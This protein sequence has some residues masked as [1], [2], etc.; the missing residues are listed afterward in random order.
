MENK[1]IAETILQEWHNLKTVLETRDKELG[2]TKTIIERINSR[3]DE[4]EA[5]LHKT[6]IAKEENKDTVSEHK[7]IF[8]HWIKTGEMI[9]VKNM[10]LRDPTTG[11]FLAPPEFV[12]KIIE[13]IV[14]FSPIREIASVRKT[15]QAMVQIPVDTG[16]P[17]FGW[18]AELGD[19]QS[20]RITFGLETINTHSISGV[21]LITRR[22][23]EDVKFDLENFLIDKATRGFAK[24]E[25][26]AFINGNSV[27]K[28]EGILFNSKI[29][30]IKSGHATSITNPDVLFNMLY[31]LKEAYAKNATW[32]MNRSTLGFL[33]T[34]KD[35]E[36][37]YI[38]SLD[39]I[40]NG[41]PSTLLGLPYVIC[42]DM[43]NIGAGSFPIVLGDF[44][45]GYLIVDREDIAVLRDPYS[46]ATQGVIRFIFY[47]AVGGQVVQ[48]EAF[49]KLQISAS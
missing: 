18:V 34:M 41:A 42:P 25:G 43:P 26:N 17:T 27:E 6:P 21:V 16:D 13:K 44:A 1:Q 5:K 9:E 3:L 14:E 49:V 31:S 10:T 24:V 32:I 40:V 30:I 8:L 23:L 2:E 11:G 12:D 7:A 45:S 38:W 47:K 37:R 33:R 22:D 46:Q 19:A 28:P 48:P 15:S 29:P 35:S 36:N 39:G 20:T 4:L